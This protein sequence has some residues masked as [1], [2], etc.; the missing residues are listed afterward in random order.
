KPVVTPEPSKPVVTPE[1]SKP[2][3][4]P[5]PSTPAETPV[6]EL[7]LPQTPEGEEEVT[8]V[9]VVPETPAEGTPVDLPLAP[10]PEAPVVELKRP[11]ALPRTGDQ[12]GFSPLLAGAGVCAIAFAGSFAGRRKK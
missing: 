2:V 9:V 12:G 3:V 8:I 1:P 4:T 5:E 6:P 11:V 10:T 7:P